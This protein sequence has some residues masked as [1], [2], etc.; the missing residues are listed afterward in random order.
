M[1]QDL[2]FAIRQLLKNPGFGLIAV[3][4][5]ALGIAA[6]TAIFSAIDAV[7]LHPLPY[8]DPDSGWFMA[9]AGRLQRRGILVEINKVTSDGR[10][11]PER[12]SGYSYRRGK[13]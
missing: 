10:R 13:S 4:A 1:I 3:I 11:G 8:P 5:L 7:S 12:V 2:R 6:N 9:A